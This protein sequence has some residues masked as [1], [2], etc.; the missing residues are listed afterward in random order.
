MQILTIYIKKIT[1]IIEAIKEA[2]QVSLPPI[3]MKIDG[4]VFSDMITTPIINNIKCLL[5]I[6]FIFTTLL[7]LMGKVKERKNEK[8]LK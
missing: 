8:L 5:E 6:L 1:N 3:S 2:S 7:K 4:Y